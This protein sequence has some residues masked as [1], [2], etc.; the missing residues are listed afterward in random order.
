MSVVGL[1]RILEN[2]RP[3]INRH[4]A[5]LN[6]RSWRP[7]RNA[8]FT[9]LLTYLPAIRLSKITGYLFQS[10]MDTCR[11]NHGHLLVYVDGI[12][13]GPNT[14][15]VTSKKKLFRVCLVTRIDFHFIVIFIWW[16]T[17]LV[18]HQIRQEQWLCSLHNPPP[19]VIFSMYDTVAYRQLSNIF[20]LLIFSFEKSWTIVLFTWITAI[21][22]YPLLS[23]VPIS[24]GNFWTALEGQL[25]PYTTLLQK[26]ILSSSA[27]CLYLIFLLLKIMLE[28][29]CTYGLLLSY[30]MKFLKKLF[31][32]TC[33]RHL[34]LKRFQIALI[35]CSGG[36]YFWTH[37]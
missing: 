20:I 28:M 16:L 5:R 17:N 6:L 26:N 14:A 25:Q 27:C 29:V 30:F 35:F 4:G 9:S 8:I 37:L 13:T 1:Q 7:S 15:L 23:L 3:K 18:T 22:Y 32:I 11:W 19:V 33:S 12:A 36:T 24:V 34:K 10:L 31:Q 2:Y 21:F